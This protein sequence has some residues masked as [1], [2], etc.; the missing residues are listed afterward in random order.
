MMVKERLKNILK[1]TKINVQFWTEP[2]SDRNEFG[3]LMKL[4]YI[5]RNM[6]RE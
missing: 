6:L 5:Y 4:E 1:R 2:F 3:Q